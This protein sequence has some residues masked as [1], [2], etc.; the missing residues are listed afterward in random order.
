MKKVIT[1][2]FTFTIL[3]ILFNCPTEPMDEPMIDPSVY[4]MRF[5]SNFA[6]DNIVFSFKWSF[7]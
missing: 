3:F 1:L 5:L 4:H 2:L 6:S 7:N